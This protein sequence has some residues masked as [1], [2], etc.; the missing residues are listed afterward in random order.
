MTDVDK[1]LSA[2]APYPTRWYAW[3]V[4]GVL[5]VAALIAY[6]DRQVVA[7]VVDPMKSDLNIG[8]AQIG[9]LYGVFAVFYAVAALPIAWLSDHKSRK[10]IIA[11]GIFLWS[12]MTMLCGITKSVWQIL[13]ARVGV[14]VGE[15]TLSPA[16]TSLIGDYFPRSQI[17][18]ALS[19]F[20]T[21]PVIGS[22]LAFIIGGAVLS[23]VEEAD[24][25]VLPIIGILSPWQQ[26]FI[27]LGLPGVFLAFLFLVIREP[28]RRKLPGNSVDNSSFA[29]TYKFYRANIRTL[30]FHH[31]GFLSL[32][33]MG[34]ALVFWTVSYFVRVHGYDA[35]SASQIFGWIFLLAG[36]IGPILVALLAKR[37]TEGG[38]PSGNITAGMIG[39]VCAMVLIISIQFVSTPFIAFCL[40]VPAMAAIN[41][42]FGVAAG[43]LPV[44]TPPQI[45]AQVAATY[46]LVGAL[47][48]MLGPPLA[49]AFN[50]FVFHGLDGV[51]YSLITLTCIFGTIGTVC[52][53]ICRPHYGISMD[54]ANEK[55]DDA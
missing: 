33:L 18:L 12:F 7:I 23:I 2:N 45:R 22:G 32:N 37:L 50:E 53:W 35:A 48:M 30:A 26:T 38:N 46:M 39:G 49:G 52:L 13:F 21:G 16:A 20:Q 51:R 28:I 29:D 40:Y 41:S 17:P 6:I 25:L 3:F 4:V 36:P 54:I 14:G 47:G 44:I 10:H 31:F 27:Y 55:F 1:N 9:W 34:Y 43:S 8:D 42:P 15:A 24:P 11:A 5:I 19:I